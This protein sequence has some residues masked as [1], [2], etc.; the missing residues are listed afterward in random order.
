MSVSN[1]GENTAH[2]QPAI[3]VSGANGE[4]DELMKT[5][6]IIKLKYLSNKSVL[7][8][9]VINIFTNCRTIANP[10]RVTDEANLV[11]ASEE[12][13]RGKS[14]WQRFC[15]LEPSNQSEKGTRTQSG[16]RP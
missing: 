8:L 7:S 12:R 2:Q 10:V 9:F 14:T 16:S 5:V 11:W 15:D 13:T 1:G 4:D 6:S 3:K